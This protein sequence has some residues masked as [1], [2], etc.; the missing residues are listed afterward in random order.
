[1]GGGTSQS[2]KYMRRL[3]RDLEYVP[4]STNPLA[5]TRNYLR[6]ETTRVIHHLLDLT[7]RSLRPLSGLSPSC[8]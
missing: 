7:P 8:A 3:S 5:T 2:G 4:S 6:A 1:M